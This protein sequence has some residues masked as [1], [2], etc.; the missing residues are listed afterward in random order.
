VGLGLSNMK[1]ITP[2][3]HDP[4]CKPV[5]PSSSRGVFETGHESRHVFRDKLHAQCTPEIGKA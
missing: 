2:I 5:P 3:R 1:A 4:R